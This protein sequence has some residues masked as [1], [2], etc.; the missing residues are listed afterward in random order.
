APAGL[1]SIPS[2]YN[3]DY[4]VILSPEGKELDT[5]PILEAFQGTPYLL[6]LVSGYES[7][8]SVPFPPG[9][10]TGGGPAGPPPGVNPPP[11]GL[12]PPAVNP[13]PGGMPLPGGLPF[14]PPGGPPGPNMPTGPSGS[15]GTIG[16][17]PP[18]PLDVLHVNSVMVLSK[19]LAPKFPMFK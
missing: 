10:A 16:P 15:N 9:G 12:P 5:I 17:P 6:T 4:V 11:G 1:D 14:P 2:R 19:A 13:P 3:A 7:T 18:D 8:T